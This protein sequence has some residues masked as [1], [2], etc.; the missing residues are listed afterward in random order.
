MDYRLCK[1]RTT[2]ENLDNV[3]NLYDRECGIRRILEPEQVDNYKQD[4]SAMFHYIYSIYQRFPN[5]PARNPLLDEEKR[6]K[7]DE[8]KDRASRLLI[9]IR[10][11][12]TRLEKRNWPNTIEQMKVLQGENNRFRAEDIPLK[13]KEKQYLMHFYREI[14]PYAA[15][16]NVY[17]DHELS[18]DNIEI[19][20]N[21][22][23]HAHQEREQA[24]LDE[25]ARLERLERFAGKSTELARRLLV[26]KIAFFLIEQK[27]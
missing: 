12:L 18:Y 23:L 2:Y 22:L 15:E 8:Y 5:P 25:I 26:T 4:E 6:M 24:I 7:I 17:I 1:E 11:N 21:R 3:F 14:A 10:E 20:W 16:L 19:M 27:K 9:W 13:Q